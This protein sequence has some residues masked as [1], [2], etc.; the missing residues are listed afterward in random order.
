MRSAC[1]AANAS[2]KVETSR[3]LFGE[4]RLGHRRTRLTAPSVPARMFRNG[5]GRA[6]LDRTEQLVL[7]TCLIQTWWSPETAVEAE[8]SSRQRRTLRF[9]R[10]RNSPDASASSRS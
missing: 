4:H 1:P 10:I 3:A 9:S 5:I 7:A 2:R 8:P 6:D